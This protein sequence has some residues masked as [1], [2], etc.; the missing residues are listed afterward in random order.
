MR[1]SQNLISGTWGDYNMPKFVGKD[2]NGIGIYQ[3][4]FYPFPNQRKWKTVRASNQREAD[5][6]F[7]TWKAEYQ[8][9]E[10]DSA[11]DTSFANIRERFEIKCKADQDCDKTIKNYRSVYR[12][13]FERFLPKEYPDI[14][15]M[16]CI[17]LRARLI[18][19]RYK[20]WV[21]VD[22]KRETGWREEL[23]K[24]RVIFSKLNAIGLCDDE[25]LKTLRTFK[26]PKKHK[27]I[28]KE[29]SREQLVKL[30][31]FIE[32]DRPDY[33][34][35][36]Y[37]V[38]RYG[39]RRDQALT[40]KAKNIKWESLRPIELLCEPQD[41]KTKEPFILKNIDPELA[42]ILKDYYL[43]AKKRNTAWLFPNRSGDRL[44]AGHYTEYI[45]V[46]S[47]KVLGIEIKPHDFRHSF[48]TMLRS[49]GRAPEDIMT[50]TGHRDPESL[51]I[52]SHASS[53]GAKQIIEE[54]RLFDK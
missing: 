54:T 39:W 52:Y 41:T 38:F 25:L 40:V 21:V 50:F 29:L 18:F 34:G 53:A 13:F 12:N 46:A 8:Q 1:L 19:E 35:A 26:R 11:Q 37:L 28:Y 49:R 17:K 15:S 10:P 31:K 3:D 9:T 2:K 33:Y 30:L 27:R 5:K 6:L 20:S 48:V 47:M 32:S 23:T 42:N 7:R 43:M 14:S 51:N 22:C 24:L 4:S 36:S 16:Q 45:K 44:H